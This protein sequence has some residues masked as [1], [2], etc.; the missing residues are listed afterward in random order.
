MPFLLCE[1]K[2]YNRISAR[3]INA[4]K[5]L[6]MNAKFLALLIERDSSVCFFCETF[7]ILEGKIVPVS[8]IYFIQRLRSL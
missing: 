6:Y 8:D 3:F 7:V 4:C 5:W 1:C 2:T